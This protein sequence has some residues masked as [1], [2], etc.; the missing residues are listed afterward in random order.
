M[1]FWGKNNKNEKLKSDG[2]YRMLTMFFSFLVP[3]FDEL[4]YQDIVFCKYV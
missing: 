2:V 1:I 4:K 3:C